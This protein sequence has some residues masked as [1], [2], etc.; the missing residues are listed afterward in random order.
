MGNK[1]SRS[2]V[3]GSSSKNNKRKFRNRN[4]G[5]GELRLASQVMSGLDED[6]D[7]ELEGIG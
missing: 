7:M 6:E 5:G 2:L 3:V 4:N 1:P